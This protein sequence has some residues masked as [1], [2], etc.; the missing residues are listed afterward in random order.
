MDITERI[1]LFNT[2]FDNYFD[3]R[4]SKEQ[5]IREKEEMLYGKEG[6]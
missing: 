6:E 1:K 5:I 4:R 3:S 2:L